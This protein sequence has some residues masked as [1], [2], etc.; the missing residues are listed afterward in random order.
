VLNDGNKQP[1][2]T[3]PSPINNAMYSAFDLFS[4]KIIIPNILNTTTFNC[5]SIEAITEPLD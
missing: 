5:P 1:I 3:K 4:L 2:I